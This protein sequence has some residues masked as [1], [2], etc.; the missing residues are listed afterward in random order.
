VSI[1]IV[2]CA[3]FCESWWCRGW[4]QS[5]KLSSQEKRQNFGGLSQHF[6]VHVSLWR[7]W[8]GL[9]NKYLSLI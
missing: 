5:P 7:L 4:T 8:A 9:T 6:L 3:W 1:P 2:L